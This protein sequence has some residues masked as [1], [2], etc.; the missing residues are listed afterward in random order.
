MSKLVI[1]FLNPSTEGIENADNSDMLSKLMA[2]EVRYFFNKYKYKPFVALTADDSKAQPLIKYL[3]KVLAERDMVFES[4][5]LA[6]S[7]V[8]FDDNY[9]VY[10]WYKNGQGVNTVYNE[11]D[12]KKRAVGF[13]LTENMEI[14]KEYEGKFKF[15]YAKSKIAGPIRGS[16]FIVKGEYK[17]P[18]LVLNE[19]K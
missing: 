15:A 13:K 17:S 16:Y 19:I 9:A 1:D 4:E 6:V 7:S 10:A 5:I 12:P 14:P 2:T 18:K 11:E 3:N 8:T